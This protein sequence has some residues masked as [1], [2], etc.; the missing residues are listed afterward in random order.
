MTYAPLKFVVATSTSLG[1]NAFKK[2]IYYMNL[3]LGSRS[4][5][6]LPVLSTSRDLCIFVRFEVAMSNGL[7]EYAFTRNFIIVVKVT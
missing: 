2:K 5:K 4:H 7:G 3:T 1:G 6:M